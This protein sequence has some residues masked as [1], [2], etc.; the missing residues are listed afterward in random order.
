MSSAVADALKKI[1][2]EIRRG[3][4]KANWESLAN[5][6]VPTWYED[7]KFGIFIHWGVYSV[8]AFGNEWYPHRMYDAKS[9]EHAYHVKHFGPVDQFGYKDF[10]PK[11]KGE[12][13][14]PHAWAELFQDAGAKFVM[15]VAEHHDGFAMYDCSFSRWN[16][17]QMGPMRDVVGQLGEA[18]RQRGMQLAVS[19]HRAENYWYFGHGMDLPSDV[20]DPTNADLYGL[21]LPRPAEHHDPNAEPAPPKKHLDE[22]LA[23][24]CELVDKYQPSVVWFDWWIFHRGFTKHVQKFAAY[25]YNR[26]KRWG[27]EVAINYKYDAFAPGTAVFDVE[28][29]QMRDI[30]PR[31]WQTDT[32]VSKSSWGYVHRHIYKSPTA[33]IHDLI[34]IVS[35]NGCLLLNVGPKPD[36]TIPS[37]EVRI[38][39]EIGHWLKINGEGIYGTRPW[40]MFGEGPTTVGEGA[41]TDTKRPPFTPA[42]FRFTTKGKTI[43]AHGLGAA[44]GRRC[45]ITAFAQNLRLLLDPVKQVTLLGDP[46]PLRFVQLA[47]RLE[48]ELPAKL[49]SEHAFVLRIES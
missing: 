40:K 27:R 8:P 20:Q 10:T 26:A 33:I 1:T 2:S 48:V 3:P 45:A 17:V 18:V 34:D 29:G 13:F 39:R 46:Q 35:K 49:P 22:W 21:R 6:T 43:Y 38:L 5:C 7:A 37:A 15:P 14:D 41:F 16:S 23:R 25:Y 28:R 9:A 4:F 36:G 42:D 24:T 31:L 47:D 12:A 30:Q 19:S 44:G 32:S 11:F